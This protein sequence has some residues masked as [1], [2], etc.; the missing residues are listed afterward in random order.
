MNTNC[1]L[2][3]PAALARPFIAADTTELGRHGRLKHAHS[4]LRGVRVI[5][6]TALLALI[7]V[8]SMFAQGL[9]DLA[10]P[11]PT[12]IRFNITYG[13][14]SENGT[15]AIGIAVGRDNY[16][17]VPRGAWYW[18]PSRGVKFLPDELFTGWPTDPYGSGLLLSG[19]GQVV[20]G[21]RW[22]AGTNGP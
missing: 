17:Q 5:V 6:V 9:V 4:I 18:S 16:S 20:V 13:Q 7:S 12:I 15:E 3:R 8:P 10:S 1:S 11:D 22:I 21:V 19:N 14:L 2:S